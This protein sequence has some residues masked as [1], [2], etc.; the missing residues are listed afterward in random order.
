MRNLIDDCTVKPRRS[1]LPVVAEIFIQIEEMRLKGPVFGTTIDLM[2][3]YWSLRMPA[4][5]RD[6][7]PLEG[8]DFH[9]LPFGWNYSPLIAQETLGDLI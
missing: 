2:N 5:M 8:P 6:L 4:V 7:F 1:P 3:F 9:S